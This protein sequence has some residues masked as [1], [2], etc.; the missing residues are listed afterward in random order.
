MIPD[1]WLWKETLT[2]LAGD[3]GA[4]V[5]FSSE[6]LRTGVDL[7]RHVDEQGQLLAREFPGYRQSALEPKR[8][9]GGRS[10]YLRR[11][12]WKPPEGEPVTQIQLYCVVGSRGYTATATTPTAEFKSRGELLVDVLEHVALGESVLSSTPE[13]LAAVPASADERREITQN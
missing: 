1:D 8:M 10:G 6:P 9:L 5:I 13:P 11:F 7:E 2:L 4:N 12:E 3:E